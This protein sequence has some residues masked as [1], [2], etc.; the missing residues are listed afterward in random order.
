MRLGQAS[1][2]TPELLLH[3]SQVGD[4]VFVGSMSVFEINALETNLVARAGLG[5]DEAEIM[6]G[7]SESILVV[8]D[9]DVQ[10]EVSCQL[11]SRLGYRVNAVESGEKAVEFVRETPQDLLILDMVMPGGIDGTETYRQILEF[12]PRQK[13]IILSGFSESDRVLEAQLLGTG[14]FVRKPITR[15]TMAAAVLKAVSELST[16]WCLPKKT[17]TQTSCT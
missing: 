7:G 8:D 13:A 10:R 17:S 14:A 1:V 12:N 9:D 4:V 15:K 2:S 11:L 3:M 6:A 5:E 16:S